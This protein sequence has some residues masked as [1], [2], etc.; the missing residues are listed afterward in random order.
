M[1]N[2]KIIQYL[3]NQ[4]VNTSI[5]IVEFQKDFTLFSYFN[6]G[7]LSNTVSLKTGYE[8]IVSSY[9]KHP[10]PTPD[11]VEYAINYL[12]DEIMSVKTL[13]NHNEKLFLK[14]KSLIRVITGKDTEYIS[15]TRQHVEDVFNQYAYLSMGKTLSNVF[16]EYNHADFAQMLILREIMHHL[17]FE[18]VNIF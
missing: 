2:L 7:T 4:N 5:R 14:A 16:T 18:E 1:E 15:V 8:F 17:N 9:F 10:V 12:E 6:N 11:D 3:F 13:L